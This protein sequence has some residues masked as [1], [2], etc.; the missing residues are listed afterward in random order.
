MRF[1]SLFLAVLCTLFM[2]VSLTS[3]SDDDDDD[4]VTTGVFILNEGKMNSNN[5]GISVYNPQTHEVTNDVYLAQNDKRLGDIG[6]DMIEYRDYV[7]VTVYGSSRLVKL[8]KAGVEMASLNFSPEDGQPRNMVA[9]NGKLYVTLYSGKV[10]CINAADLK[11]EKYVEV[12]KNPEQIVEEDGRL[13]VAN[14][15]YGEGNTV[16]VIDLKTF[17]VIETVPVVLNP[18]DLEEA[19]GYVYVISWGDWGAIPYTLSRINTRTYDV[20][21]ITTATKMAEHDDILYLA[22]SQTDWSTY[23]TTTT[24]F[25]YDAKRG[26]LNNTSFLQDSPKAQELATKSVY[27]IE[28]DPNNGDIY[29][30]V[31]DYNNNGDVYRFTKTGEFVREITTGSL[32]PNNMVFFD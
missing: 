8:D 31:S 4:K 7:Y 32:N 5:A 13:Y 3:C 11:I 6:Q 25:T 29:I 12:G 30:G 28:I 2:G 20:E 9:E 16:S 19:E 15:G 18:N 22:N 17:K 23:T 24:F 27:M 1:R 21:E 14:S 10:A 26:V